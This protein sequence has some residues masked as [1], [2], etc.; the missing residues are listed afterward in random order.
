[1][2]QRTYRYQKPRKMDERFDKES[3]PKAIR[4]IL[5]T[6]WYNMCI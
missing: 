1:M 3:I 4:Q 2:A 5:Q 6:F